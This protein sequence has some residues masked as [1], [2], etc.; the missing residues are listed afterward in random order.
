MRLTEV[1]S[2][3]WAQVDMG[4]MT[5]RI[6]DTR[7]G[8]PLEF[9]VPRQ[10][11]AILE[12]RHAERE[13]FAAETRGWVFPSETG[14]SGHL[15]SIQDLNVRIEVAGGAKSWF[16]AFRNCF[17]TVADQSDQAA[18]QPCPSLDTTQGCAAA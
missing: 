13:R 16:N 1:I 3:A 7:S 15:E 6:E 9:P 11:A 17:I 2:L 8:E 4:T 18:R 14:T 5:V 12:R 10:F